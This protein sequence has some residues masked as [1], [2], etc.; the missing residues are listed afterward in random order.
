MAIRYADPRAEIRVG[1][2]L[3]RRH[4][5]VDCWRCQ[6]GLTRPGD[7]R[8]HSGRI[9]THSHPGQ[10]SGFG[11]IPDRR[12]ERK[13][14]PGHYV[15]FQNSWWL[16]QFFSS[17]RRTGQVPRAYPALSRAG[18]AVARSQP[19]TAHKRIS[20]KAVRNAHGEPMILRLL[21][22][23]TKSVFHSDEMHHR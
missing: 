16:G 20:P 1:F 8:A 13:N 7:R 4:L 14:S 10:G 22:K 5:S 9:S 19:T 21:S 6:K 17:R 12:R 2:W 23:P 15:P 11:S 18:A 3:S